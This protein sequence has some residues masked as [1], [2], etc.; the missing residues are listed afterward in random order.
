[1][2]SMYS[3]DQYVLQRHIKHAAE[4]CTLMAEDVVISCC[5]PVRTHAHSRFKRLAVLVMYVYIYVIKIVTAVSWLSALK[6]HQIWPAG[7]S[8]HL[9]AA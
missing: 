4:L 2:H 3:P 5:Y 6:K 8:L 7:V 1:M 9:H